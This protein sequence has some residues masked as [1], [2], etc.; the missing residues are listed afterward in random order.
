MAMPPSSPPASSESPPMLRPAAET[1]PGFGFARSADS[2]LLEF[3]RDKVTKGNFRAEVSQDRVRVVVDWRQGFVGRGVD[4]FPTGECYV[5]YFDAGQRSG[6]GTFRHANGQT[7][8]SN[9]KLN[10]PVG[11]GV[12]WAPDGSKA[13]LLE[14]G[15]PVKSITVEEGAKIAADLKIPVPREW[16]QHN[17]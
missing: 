14:N 2:E 3:A 10:A 6:P 13:A 12:Q 11:V 9:W 17:S 15:K 16:F 7:L 8:V 4:K 5:G 1:R